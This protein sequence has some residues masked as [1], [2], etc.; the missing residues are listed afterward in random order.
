MGVRV[1]MTNLEH[2]DLSEENLF[3]RGISARTPFARL[4]KRL[5]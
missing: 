4:V 5:K 1:I 2:F 3:F